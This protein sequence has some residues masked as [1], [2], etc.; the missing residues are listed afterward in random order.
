MYEWRITTQHHICFFAQKQCLYYVFKNVYICMRLQQN[1]ECISMACQSTSSISSPLLFSCGGHLEWQISCR[2]GDH[3]CTK[4]NR[5]LGKNWQNKG[6]DKN[7]ICHITVKFTNSFWHS[8]CVSA[9]ATSKTTAIDTRVTTKP[10][11]GLKKRFDPRKMRK[12]F[13][14]SAKCF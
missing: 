3:C 4:P 13:A 12:Q 11:S 1:G 9:R 8:S 14:F 6:K 2:L 7:I 5:G 10:Y